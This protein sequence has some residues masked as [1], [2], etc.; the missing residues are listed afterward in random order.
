MGEGHSE[1][2]MRDE[3]HDA[4]RQQTGQPRGYWAKKNGAKR[5]RSLVKAFARNS[6]PK[7]RASSPAL[8][9]A[10]LLLQKCPVLCCPAGI[11]RHEGDS[12][13]CGTSLGEVDV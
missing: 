2:E 12:A 4:V 7:G 10:G 11:P 1:R 13:R 3:R 5:P 8:L 9:L 6:A